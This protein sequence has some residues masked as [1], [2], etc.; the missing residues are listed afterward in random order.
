MAVGW[1]S[2][3]VGAD[4][5]VHVHQRNQGLGTDTPPVP[6]M[7]L[8]VLVVG[9]STSRVCGVR[10][11]AQ[12]L[13]GGLAEVGFDPV[14]EW[15]DFSSQP[16]AAEV[17]AWLRRVEARVQRERPDIILFHYSVFTLAWRGI[18]VH[19]LTVTHR[20]AHLGLPVV[21]LLH[22]YA[23]PWGRSGW[24]GVAWATTQRLAL[25]LVVSRAAALIVT[26]PQ[27]A[28]WTASRRWLPRRPVAVAPVFS[29]LPPAQPLHTSTR[30][31]I[32]V[33]LFGYG[34]EAVPLPMLLDALS[35]LRQTTPE[36]RLLLL[37][38]P[39][40]DSASGRHVLALARQRGLAD[41]L[42]FTGVLSAQDLSDALASCD[43]L[44]FVDSDGPSSRKGTLAASLA[45]G[46]PVV[47]LDG[48]NTWRDLVR[49]Q[50]IALVQPTGPALAVEVA[51][52]L[53]DPS[54]A[55][56]LGSRGRAFADR[57]MSVGRAAA[58]VLSVVSEIV[59]AS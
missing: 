4:S 30:A 54:A 51:R 17:D 25:W 11:H 31:G 46:R 6:R 27:R 39:G 43:I 12:I 37:G 8:R 45:S 56:A 52:L 34:H 16:A 44:L 21:I 33:G 3:P 41:V 9:A 28:E 36:A 32:R 38:A 53:A 26:T 49:G 15:G 40:P 47:A 10:D 18:P 5:S 14:V 59:A 48:P 35:A 50:A 58:A 24:R 1:R 55:D 7:T 57:N 20:L 29:N 2:C 22:E 42:D 13:S 23:Y 19:A